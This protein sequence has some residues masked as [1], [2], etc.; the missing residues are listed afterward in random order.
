MLGFQGFSIQWIEASSAGWG[1]SLEMIWGQGEG[2]SQGSRR[3]DE[4]KLGRDA[5]S[6]V[7]GDELK[8]EWLLWVLIG[9]AGS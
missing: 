4:L 3:R 8:E 2:G 9:A 1:R 5:E 6:S 7:M